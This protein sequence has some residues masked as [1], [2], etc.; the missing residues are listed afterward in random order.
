M[1]KK[2]ITYA[3]FLA[4][5]GMGGNALADDIKAESVE[6][7]PAQTEV[8]APVKEQAKLQ[9]CEPVPV[10]PVKKV[11]KKRKPN[12]ADMYNGNGMCL[13]DSV[14]ASLGLVPENSLT[15]YCPGKVVPTDAER[16]PNRCYN[17]AGVTSLDLDSALANLPNISDLEQFA[18]GLDANKCKADYRVIQAGLKTAD[19]KKTAWQTAET[20]LSDYVASVMKVSEEKTEKKETVEALTPYKLL[21]QELV[22]EKPKVDVKKGKELLVEVDKT[23]KAYLEEVHAV[24]SYVEK[25]KKVGC[26]Y[27]AP[28]RE[29]KGSVDVSLT[30]KAVAHGLGDDGFTFAG[31]LDLDVVRSYN[32]GWGIGGSVNLN[33]T[34]YFDPMSNTEDYR[35]ESINFL[36][37]DVTSTTE[38]ARRGSATARAEKKWTSWLSTHL[39]GGIAVVNESSTKSIVR[40]GETLPR[41]SESEEKVA[42]ESTFGVRFNPWEGL[43]IDLEGRANSMGIYDGN[44]GLGWTFSNPLYK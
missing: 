10:A 40:G 25:L 22:A 31:E 14:A 37:Q 30:G 42:F 26:A 15:G 28:K 19:M 20:D 27:E 5:V 44:L 43:T 24:N 2:A 13:Q 7:K 36:T 12:C 21:S 9:P 34:N 41:V 33:G 1:F 23:K 35:D 6:N 16:N 29:S 32:N 4:A 17:T 3:A 18:L 8:V 39:E 11:V 38:Y